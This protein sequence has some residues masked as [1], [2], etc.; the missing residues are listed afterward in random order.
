M[1]FIK[2][3]KLKLLVSFIIG[4]ISSLYQ[5]ESREELHITQ[6]IVMLNKNR[7]FIYDFLTKVD[8]YPKVWADNSL[9]ANRDK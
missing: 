7:Q 5:L 6:K 2:N 9:L 8:E 4:A 1:I 3:F